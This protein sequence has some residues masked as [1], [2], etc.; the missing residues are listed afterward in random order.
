M[1]NEDEDDFD[2]VV[3]EDEISESQMRLTRIPK[4]HLDSFMAFSL[5]QPGSF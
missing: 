1:D 4:A 5:Y 2:L 3:I